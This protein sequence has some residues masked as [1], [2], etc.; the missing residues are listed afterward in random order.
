MKRFARLKKDK[1]NNIRDS[2]ITA[3]VYTVSFRKLF[4]CVMTDK[5]DITY[6][7][8]R[9]LSSWYGVE[10]ALCIFLIT[11]NMQFFIFEEQ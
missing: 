11:A 10:V 9:K 3:K 7:E 2:C 6:H 8:V 1:L 5:R 4:D